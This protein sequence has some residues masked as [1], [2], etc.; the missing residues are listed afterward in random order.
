VT[1]KMYR[2][3]AA[4]ALIA[5]LLLARDDGL[6][7]GWPDWLTGIAIGLAAVLTIRW[8]VA[9]ARIRPVPTETER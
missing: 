3:L 2:L 9:A 7:E 8:T 4:L 1:E 6:A 5:A